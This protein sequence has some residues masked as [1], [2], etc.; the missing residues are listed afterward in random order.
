V[1]TPE[2][3]AACERSHTGQFLREVMGLEAVYQ[4]EKAPPIREAAA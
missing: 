2:E 1:G 3:V 4:H